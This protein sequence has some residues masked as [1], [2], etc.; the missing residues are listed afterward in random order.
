MLLRQTAMLA[1]TAVRP[2]PMLHHTLAR[3]GASPHN[4]A[5]ALRPSL[6]AP[7]FRPSLAAPARRAVSS[8]VSVPVATTVRKTVGRLFSSTGESAKAAATDV[9]WY[10]SEKGLM[11]LGNVTYLLQ[12][13][14]FLMTV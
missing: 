9:P 11:V 6:A 4:A 12:L 1:R 7:A 2:S 13:G 3:C 10:Q 14:G 5:R 8:G